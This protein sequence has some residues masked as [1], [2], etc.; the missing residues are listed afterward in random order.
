MCEELVDED[1][2]H[3]LI[4]WLSSE[5]D[6]E[7]IRVNQKV[8]D[9]ITYRD[10]ASSVLAV[11]RTFSLEIDD[12]PPIEQALYVVAAGLEKPGNLGSILRSTDA[13][14]ADGVILCDQVTD[15]FN[16]NVVQASVG[17]IFSVPIACADSHRAIDWLR[18]RHVKIIAASPQGSISYTSVNLRESSAVVIGSEAEGL[19]T[20]WMDAADSVVSLPQLGQSDSLNAAMT[21]TVLM[22]EARRQ[23]GHTL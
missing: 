3:G 6:P 13:A 21:A 15:V 12:F 2:L 11:A 16:P 14:G 17:T 1:L 22:F 20:Q 4:Q 9:R 19:S 23:R 5:C 18:E 10:S 8:M 7:I